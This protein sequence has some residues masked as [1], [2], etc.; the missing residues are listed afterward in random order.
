[1]PYVE[2]PP[3]DLEAPLIAEPVRREGALV[4]VSERPGLGADPD[5]AVLARY[6]YGRHAAR[7]FIL[8]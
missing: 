3:G 4:G 8:T 5:P 1:V 7:P 2:F 6:P